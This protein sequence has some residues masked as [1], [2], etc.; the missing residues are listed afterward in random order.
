MAADVKG[1]IARR[2]WNPSEHSAASAKDEIIVIT[3]K[4]PTM[5]KPRASTA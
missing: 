4:K 1:M 5:Q 3:R 2:D